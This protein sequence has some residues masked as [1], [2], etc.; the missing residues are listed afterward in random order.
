[1]ALT[2]GVNME[3]AYAQSFHN[4]S[5]RSW[6]NLF[7]YGQ[8]TWWANERYYQLHGEYVPW[9]RYANAWQWR[10]RAYD[11]GW[12]VS[13]RPRFG[14]IVDLQ[15]WVQGASG[16]GHVA[17]VERVFRNGHVLASNMNWGAHPRRITYVKF[18]PG[19]GVRFIHH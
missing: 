11:F 1:M 18:A 17:V 5:D 12:H 16:L 6:G 4:A 7:P 19:A 15:P 8:C 2:L 9:T 3:G 14:D 10:A 13:R